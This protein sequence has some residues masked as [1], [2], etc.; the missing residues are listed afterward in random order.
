MSGVKVWATEPIYRNPNPY[1]PQHP[2]LIQISGST[3][4]GKSNLLLNMC[5]SPTT[6]YDALVIVFGVMQPKLKILQEKF[7]GKGGVTL[8]E[9]VPD[10]SEDQARVQKML[11]QNNKKGLQTA[12]VLEDV[13]DE[14]VKSKWASR[15]F[16]QGS[17]HLNLSIISLCQK[18]FCNRE[19]RLQSTFLILMSFP[20]D[21]T[22]IFALARQIMPEKPK[23]L[24]EMYNQTQRQK[25][26]WL[27][28]DLRAERRGRP[29]LKY[30][31]SSFTR[32]FD[33]RGER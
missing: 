18:V 7:K 9:G 10:N 17:H 16:T 27:G 12:V 8:I 13:M 20:A 3:G 29:E 2:G 21:K 14:V 24:M 33:I 5:L 22:A 31:D 26:G 1:L 30:R 4:S 19:Q 23:V 25:F 28:I 11:E 6:A 15:L 32:A